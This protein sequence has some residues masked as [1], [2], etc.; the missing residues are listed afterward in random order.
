MA[1]EIGISREAVNNWRAGTSRPS[2]RHRDRV[3]ACANYLRL[4]EAECN[5]LLQS[6]GFEP[7]FP[8][9]PASI[10]PVVDTVAGPVPATVMRVFDRLQGLR[11]YPVSLLLTQAHWGQPPEREAI[12]AE[13]AARYGQD[14]V[15]HLQPPFRAGEGDQDY[16]ALLAAQCGL[17]GVTSD[18]GFEMALARR[19]QESGALF[20]L[21]SRFE[22]GAPGPR[23]V[24]A[25]ILR[26]LS[27]MYSGKLHLLICGGAALA[28]LKYQGGDLSLLNIAATETW[29]ELGLDDLRRSAA[30]IADATLSH[31]LQLSGGHPLL[32]QAALLLLADT[33]LDDEAM[34]DAL[35]THP[36]LWESLLPMLRDVTARHAVRGWLGRSPVAPARPYLMDPLLRQL[37]WSNLLTPR[38]GA[39][40]A[41]LEWRC[42]AIRRAV[43]QV[44][45]GLE[46]LPA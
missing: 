40:G 16:F 24:L 11:P 27:E 1:A 35:S 32:A 21:V 26:S 13:A 23:D 7:E 34:I 8:V 3:L 28:D 44:I 2:R 46:A 31:A 5:A 25:G 10:L 45:D 6:V 20:C 41:G 36:R 15:L 22:Q 38:A 37:Y 17:D 33:T 29:P 4:T 14:R 42:E 18:A 9:E 12:L 39:Q 30:G 43:R 19:L